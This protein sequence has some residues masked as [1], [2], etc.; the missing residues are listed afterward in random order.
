MK[1]REF[2]KSPS[3]VGNYFPRAIFALE[4]L[5][6]ILIKSENLWHDG[7]GGIA[8]FIYSLTRFEPASNN[9]PGLVWLF[10]VHERVRI[11]DPL[12]TSIAE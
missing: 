5:Y 1:Y 6:D 2:M 11:Y 8:A 12:S 7:I 10:A 4:L 3:A 9:L